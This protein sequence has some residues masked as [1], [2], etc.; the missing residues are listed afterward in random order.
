MD[1]L[2]RILTNNPDAPVVI[3]LLIWII[4]QVSKIKVRITAM[5]ND[6]DHLFR[7]IIGTKQSKHESRNNR[8]QD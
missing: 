5:Q 8:H 2:L 1:E 7:A 4:N 3:I 6:I